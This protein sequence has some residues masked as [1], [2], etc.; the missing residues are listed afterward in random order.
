MQIFKRFFKKIAKKELSVKRLTL[1]F[2]LG[3]FIA[4]SPF[5]GI[6]TLMAFGIPWLFGL[7]VAVVVATLY[8]FN[9]PL[10][11][12]A[13]VGAQYFLGHL[14]LVDL[15]KIDVARYNPVWMTHFNDWLSTTWVAKHA[16][17]HFS[18]WSFLVGSL[19]S[20]IF[21]AVLLYP[22]MRPVFGAIINGIRRSRKR[23][24]I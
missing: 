20:G 13:I 9:N 10:T 18:V 21:L 2:C 11:M 12:C 23:E 22:V 14:V 1:S 15:L 3:F 4:F 5:W 19:L 7:N 6:H 17:T 16:S 24:I 8:L